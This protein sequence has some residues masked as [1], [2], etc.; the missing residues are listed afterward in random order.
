MLGN[1]IGIE[2]NVVLLKLKIELDKIQS[3]INMYVVFEEGKRLIVGEIIDIK[4][5]IAYINL[6]GEFVN[7]KFVFGVIKKVKVYTLLN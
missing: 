1:V 2:E 6:L 4:E 5:S 7:E 3:L